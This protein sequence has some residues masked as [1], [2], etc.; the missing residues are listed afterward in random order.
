MAGQPSFSVFGADIAIRGDVTAGTDLHIDGRIDGD[1]ACAT[2]VQGESSE[3]T[4][5]ITA[6]AARL[7][8]SVK[9][10]IAVGELTILKTAR[11]EGDVSYD[12]LTIEPGASVEGRFG[13][14]REEQAE[15]KLTLA[16]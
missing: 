13:H 7:A 10:T 2:L 5:A 3:I 15:P 6:K 11:I 12:T 1:V 4:G 8:G 14:R 9:G 16:K